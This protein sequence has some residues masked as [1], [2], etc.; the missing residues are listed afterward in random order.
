VTGGPSLVDAASGG[1]T[2]VTVVV[3]DVDVASGT[4]GRASG[5]LSCANLRRAYTLTI[6]YSTSAAKTKTR[7]A[8]IQTSNCSRHLRGHPDVDRFDVVDSRQ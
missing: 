6:A 3:V 1:G 2:V 4:S 8:D 5:G 7:Q